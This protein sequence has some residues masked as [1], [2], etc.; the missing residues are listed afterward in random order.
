M[1]KSQLKQIIKEE[2]F[3]ILNENLSSKEEEALENLFSFYIDQNYIAIDGN[4]IKTDKFEDIFKANIEDLKDQTPKTGNRDCSTG[5]CSFNMDYK[6]EEEHI[7]FLLSIKNKL[8]T[9]LIDNIG[10]KIEVSKIGRAHV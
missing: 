3:K 10:N 4:E 1:K 2:I 7:N 8:I 6:D 9:H 5:D